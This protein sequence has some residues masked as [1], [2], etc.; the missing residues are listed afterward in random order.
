MTIIIEHE[1]ELPFLEQFRE[2]ILK[3][4]ELEKGIADSSDQKKPEVYSPGKVA[5]EEEVIRT[6][7][8]T[9]KADEQ[10]FHIPNS[11]SDFDAIRPA[12]YGGEANPFEPIKIIE[13]YDLNFSMG[14][15]IKYIL[16][17]GKKCGFWQKAE[18]LNK[19][20]Q[21]LKFEIKRLS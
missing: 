16:R 19:A 17:A 8:A 18:D 14:N 12:H 4:K 5:K 20:I 15:A 10:G 7:P 11:K 1:S 9:K 6:R 3:A 2:I 13:H 21:Y